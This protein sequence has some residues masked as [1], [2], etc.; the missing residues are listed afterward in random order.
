MSDAANWIN[1]A[2]GD[3]DAARRCLVDPPNVAAAAQSTSTLTGI[4]PTLSLRGA[5]ADAISCLTSVPRLVG[6]EIASSLARL[7]MT[8]LAGRFR[9]R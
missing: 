5:R 9:S 7:A 3:L 8:G 6:Q 4:I 2:D 1:A